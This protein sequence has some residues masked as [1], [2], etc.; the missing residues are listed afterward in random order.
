MFYHH[1]YISCVLR[2]QRDKKYQDAKQKA[3]K[4]RNEYLLC[5]ESANCS[6]YKYFVEDLSDI[7]DVSTVIQILSVLYWN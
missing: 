3:S 6:I 1:S 7:I 2:V 4:A 5:M